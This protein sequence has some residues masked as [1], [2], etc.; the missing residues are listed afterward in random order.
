MQWDSPYKGGT[1]F[2]KLTLPEDFPF[3]APSVYSTIVSQHGDL[4]W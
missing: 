4:H 1:F 3:K 2:F